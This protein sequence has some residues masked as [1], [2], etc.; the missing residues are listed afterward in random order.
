MTTVIDAI[1]RE[2]LRSQRASI[3]EVMQRSVMFD[4]DAVRIDGRMIQVGDH[5]VADFASCN[6]LGFDL[7][8]EIIASVE[9][10]RAHV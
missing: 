1:I 2:N 5:W 3:Q 10:G 7:D 6:Y 8:E 9:I 4:A